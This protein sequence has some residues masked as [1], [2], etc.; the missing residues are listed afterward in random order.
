[1]RS[2][3][4]GWIPAGAREF[5][6]PAM[7]GSPIY[8]SLALYDPLLSCSGIKAP[9]L[10]IDV[11]HE[12]LWSVED[13]GLGAFKRIPRSVQKEYYVIKGAKHYDAYLKNAGE[14][15]DAALRFFKQ[16]LVASS[17]HL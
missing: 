12:E 4:T 5:H 13:N 9:T 17:P 2:A 1:V 16:H 10:I 8:G 6:L 7:D 15:R 3:T 11:E 14:A